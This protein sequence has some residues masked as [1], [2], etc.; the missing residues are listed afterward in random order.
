MTPIADRLE[1]AIRDHALGE[2]PI[3]SQREIIRMRFSDLML[4]YGNWRARLVEPRV[5][6]VHRSGEL[7]RDAKASDNRP[8]L[9]AL[10]TKIEAGESLKPHLSDRVDVAHLPGDRTREK[11]H[12]RE[13]RDL[14][15]AD[16]GIHHLHL[17]TRMR[18][19]GEFVQRTK[20][21]LFAIFTPSDAYLIGIY[22]HGSWAAREVLGRVISNWPETELVPSS[23]SA[24]GLSQ[25]YSDDEFAQ[26][27]NAG[28]AQPVEIDGKVYMPR[29][30]TTAGTPID[31]TSRVNA[32]IWTLEDWRE[33]EA[34]LL[35]EAGRQIDEHMG[36]RIAGRWEAAVHDGHCGLM[37]G[38]CFLALAALP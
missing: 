19:D 32:L 23:L 26:L 8:A 9:E 22:P 10:V 6:Q 33:N 16:W 11:L 5:R 20:D 24:V 29:G 14:M 34:D 12:L 18:D 31:V 4:T 28:I 15:L 21:L 25:S 2:M 27:R 17:S 37:R 1:R 30:Q 38:G 3:D 13:D 36:R 7:D 35:T